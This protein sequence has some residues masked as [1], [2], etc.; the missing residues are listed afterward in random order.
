MQ[1]VWPQAY[2]GI[3]KL[4]L[5]SPGHFAG[6]GLS[7]QLFMLLPTSRFFAILP[8]FSESNKLTIK[9]WEKYGEP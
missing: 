4:P 2:Y 3:E 5:A 8:R 9:L 1:V 6:A 7:A